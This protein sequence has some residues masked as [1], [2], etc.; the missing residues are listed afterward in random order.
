MPIKYGMSIIVGMSERN[1]SMPR[2]NEEVVQE[3]RDIYR[4]EFGGAQQQ[5]FL[6]SWADL[7]DL[8][9]FGKLFESRFGTLVE[10][11]ANRGLYLWN[12]PEGENGHQVAVIAIRTVD[13]W[14]RV[15]RR[16]VGEH[17][18]PMDDLSDSTEDDD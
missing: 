10:A 7:R 14:R 8:Y 6:I 11:A 15:P 1:K 2:T 18:A 16:I 4:S 17:R 5:R 13:R 9:G 3:L 12:L